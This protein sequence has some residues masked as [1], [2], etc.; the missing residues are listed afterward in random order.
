[1]HILSYDTYLTYE[2]IRFTEIPI[3]S[4]CL[5]SVKSKSHLGLGCKVANEMR[6]STMA[7]SVYKIREQDL[8]ALESH[9]SLISNKIII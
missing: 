2:P 9:I 4:A 5:I 7:M 1:M 8:L 6:T 3:N